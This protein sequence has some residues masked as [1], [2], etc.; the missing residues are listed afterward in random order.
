MIS[1]T[2]LL[3]IFIS[4]ELFES[5]LQ[6]SDT[7]YG[8]IDKNYQLYNKNIFLFFSMQPSFFYA[9]FLSMYLNNFSFWMSSIVVMK[10]LDIYTKLYLF[11][12]ID[13]GENIDEI[14]PVDMKIK[15]YYLFLNVILYPLAFVFATLS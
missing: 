13:S 14:I 1:L 15:S 5:T 2:I 9:I 7:F 8:V 6:K 3:T 4:L 12:K 11:K 10:F